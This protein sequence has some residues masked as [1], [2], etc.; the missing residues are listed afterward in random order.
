MAKP[1]SRSSAKKHNSKKKAS[2]KSPPP[3]RN[4]PAADAR[5]STARVEKSFV[6]DGSII[7]YLSQLIRFSCFVF[8]N[9]K[10]KL[11][12]DHL[13][14]M[15]EADNKDKEEKNRS[16]TALR[17][18][19]V[20]AAD[21]IK[22]LRDGQHHNSFL[23]ID[24]DDTLDYDT[25]VEYMTTKFNV[26][27]VER[28]CAE[29]Y[30]KAL[31]L[32]DPITPEMVVDDGRVRLKVFQS[33]EQYNGIRSAIG[34]VYKIARVEMPFAQELGIY[35]KGITRHI[36]AAK[37]HLGLKLTKGK[38][39]M[40]PQAY[41]MIAEHLF[42]SGEKRDIFNH[43]MFVLD[44]NLMKRSE[45]CLNVKM[46]HIEFEDDYL[47]FIF[48]KEKGK[49]HGDMHGP[50]HCFANPSK[51]HICLVLAFA[52][53]IFA[54]PEVLQA[55]MPLFPGTNQYTRYSARMHNL[56]E[57][58]KD[59]L[60]D[61]GINWEEL[62]THSVR[63]GVGSM[64]ANASTVGPPIVALCLRAGW[65][66]GG[67]KEM[68]LF[69][70]DAGDLN[71]GR[72][73]ACLDIE[74]KEFG[75]SPPY[76]DCSDLDEDGKL[77]VMNKVERWM[78]ERIPKVDSIPANSW[79]LAVQC[80]ASVCYQH[81]YL[82]ANLDM[83][84]PLR[85]ALVFRDIPEEFRNRAKVAFPW[86]KTRDTPR[87]NG[88]PPHVLHIAKMEELENKIDRMEENLMSRIT[89]EMDTRGFSSTEYKTSSIKEALASVVEDLTKQL[90]DD[91][92]E[93]KEQLR[94]CR[95]D[96]ISDPEA[97]EPPSFNTCT[98]IDEDADIPPSD[99]DTNVAELNEGS[100][101]TDKSTQLQKRKAIKRSVE[102]MKKRKFTVG[103]HHNK[104]NVLPPKFKFPSMAVAN[105]V[106]C[107][108]IGNVEENVPAL[109]TLSSADVLHFKSKS[110]AKIGN[111][112]RGKMKPFM[113]IVEKR[114]RREGVWIEKICDWTPASVTRMWNAISAEFY[115]DFCQS[116][117][118]LELGWSTAYGRMT[119]ANAFNNPRNKKEIAKRLLAEQNNLV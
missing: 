77:A 40:K 88:I 76:F 33:M 8:D 3:S 96:Y 18:Y 72:R 93:V 53:Y 4:A 111:R 9:Y 41:E 22:P 98:I 62:G 118:P 70:Q 103:Y 84:C 28:S 23:K 116:K 104:L 63:K 95:H 2:A 58:L 81:S 27:E 71:V 46:I 37:Q 15:T 92:K 89:A 34:W 91:L 60:Y 78:K 44:W 24:G 110:G 102:L 65:T 11:A 75:I 79:N 14:K 31:K 48:E 105:F 87:F 82:L 55:G 10:G 21:A 86:N 49:Q 85:F 83:A 80:F 119:E 25:V 13:E 56:F 26:V 107:W 59:D 68:Y 51:P 67:V 117:R 74:T 47:K 1:T 57:E 35:I 101:G 43:L 113:G 90:R 106:T 6:G 38:A 94:N 42:K 66:L 20:H 100:R 17:N 12:D 61:I 5:A 99:D 109:A 54:F 52:R 73:A 112:V 64:V 16:R 69:R 32:T 115:A 7:T 108:L 114:A 36:A 45:N 97:A 29:K 39:V 19:V 30:M 50:W